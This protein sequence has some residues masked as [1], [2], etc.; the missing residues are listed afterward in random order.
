MSDPRNILQS[1]FKEA[2]RYNNFGEM[3]IRIQVKGFRCHGNTL[4]EF[5]SPI[6]A[7]CGLNG[8]GKST[9]LQLAAASYTNSEPYY[10]KHFMV[11]GTLDPTPFRDDALVEFKFWQNDRTLKPLTLSRNAS[12]KRW[13]GY[14]RRP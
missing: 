5:A 13:Q 12:T 9:F 14:S 1:M 8:T 3:L 4:V 2:D 7:F 6:T 10:I 11:V